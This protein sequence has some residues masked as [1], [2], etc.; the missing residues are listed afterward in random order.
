M[1][2]EEQSRA[3]DSAVR[4]AKEEESERCALLAETLASIHEASAARA[5]KEGSYVVRALWPFGARSVVVR[6]GAERTARIME[7]AASSLRVV[8]TACRAGWDPR[9]IVEQDPNEQAHFAPPT[10]GPLE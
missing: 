5:R 7:A 4:Y 2:N 6:P 3:I 8:A 10:G 1:T 9:T